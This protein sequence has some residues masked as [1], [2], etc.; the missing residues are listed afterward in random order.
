MPHAATVHPARLARGLAAEVERLGGVVHEQT[1]VRSIR[2]RQVLTDHGTVRADV[3]VRCTEAY[4]RS[5]EGYER[6]VVPLANH[7]IATEPIDESTWAEIG[8]ADRQ[9]FELNR[10]LLGYGHRTGDGRIV[11]GG[12]AAPG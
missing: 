9:L 2:E 1:R 11:W 8:L 4:T 12:L 3:V 7:V 10:V 6:D 5:I